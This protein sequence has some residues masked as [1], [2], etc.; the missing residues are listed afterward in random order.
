MSFKFRPMYVHPHACVC[1]VSKRQKANSLGN[2][3]WSELGKQNIQGKKCIR[4]L[5][6][7]LSKMGYSVV[8]YHV[9]NAKNI[10]EIRKID[11]QRYLKSL[12]DIKLLVGME[13]SGGI[14]T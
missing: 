12:R 14:L 11:K 8:N 13:Y 7:V 2:I 9:L 6:S 10:R 4:I 1:I 3:T 5:R